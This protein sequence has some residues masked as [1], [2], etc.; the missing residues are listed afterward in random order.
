MTPCCRGVERERV[1]E[2]PAQ[3]FFD[4][5]IAYMLAEADM[6]DAIERIV[7]SVK[8]DLIDNEPPYGDTTYDY[9]DRSFELKGCAADLELSR[10]QRAA[11]WDLGFA[12]CWLC[13]ETRGRR[14][15][16]YYCGSIDAS[17]TPDPPK[18]GE[19]HRR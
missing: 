7:C 1:A 6:N 16:R 12:R 3:R 2:S 11:L 10:E 5:K 8:G 18:Y 9:Y 14:Y 13:Y 4:A 19:M 15:E 17:E